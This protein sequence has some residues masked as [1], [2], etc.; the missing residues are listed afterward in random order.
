MYAHTQTHIYT[1]ITFQ[2]HWNCQLSQSDV[3]LIEDGSNYQLR[4]KIEDREERNVD[5]VDWLELEDSSQYSCCKCLSNFV[6]FFLC[7]FYFPHWLFFSLPSSAFNYHYFCFTSRSSSAR[8]EKLYQATITVV[9]VV[10][11]SFCTFVAWELFAVVLFFLRFI[12][13]A[14]AVGFLLWSCPQGWPP[15]DVVVSFI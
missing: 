10:I 13:L 9:V 14:F 4:P 12:A 11:I 8:I 3:H 15:R 1:G 6:C 5:S 2:L 7:F